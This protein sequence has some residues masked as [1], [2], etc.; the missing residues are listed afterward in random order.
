MA[1]NNSQYNTIFRAYEQKQLHA[2][3]Q[4]DERIRLVHRMVPEYKELQDSISS[5]SVQQARKLLEGDE[6]ALEEL[7]V[8]IRAL[9][10]KC[11]TLLQ[12]AGF[13]EDFLEPVYE[14][15]DCKDT[16]VSETGERCKC[17]SEKLKQFV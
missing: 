14:C 8:Q 3:E 11:K 6:N 16:G 9:S 12:D 4:L 2:R 1:L 15:K 10:Q 7:K 13:A 17:F 5:L